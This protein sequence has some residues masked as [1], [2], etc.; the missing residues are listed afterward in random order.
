MKIL[1]EKV[2]SFRNYTQWGTDT[3]LFLQHL[4]TSV[5]VLSQNQWNAG[6]HKQLSCFFFTTS[7]PLNSRIKKQVA[8]LP[9]HTKSWITKKNK[10]ICSVLVLF[11]LPCKRQHYIYGHVSFIQCR[12][13][14]NTNPTI[15]KQTRTCTSPISWFYSS[16]LLHLGCVV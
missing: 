4:L 15:M 8:R 14:T 6:Q 12:I 2:F 10:S 16:I 13:N 7:L 11:I 5:R 3:S 1:W 9:I